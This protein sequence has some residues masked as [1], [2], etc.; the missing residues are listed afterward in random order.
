MDNS[1]KLLSH[2]Y[3]AVSGLAREFN[4][5]T[6]I[7]GRIGSM[8]NISNVQVISSNWIQGHELYNVIKLLKLSLPIILRGNFSSVFFHMT[9]LQCALLSPIIKIRGRRQ[10]LWYAHTHKSR[11]LLF[12]SLF[13]T[14][15]V[16]STLGSCPIKRKS[17]IPIGQAI[18]QTLFHSIPYNNLHLGKLV[19][20][21]RFD[22]SKNI[23][24]LISSAEILKKEFPEIELTIIG[25]P[26]NLESNKWAASLVENSFHK[27]KEG[28]LTFMD[29][30][31]RSDIPDEMKNYGVFFHAYVGSLDKTLIESTMMGIPV[32]TLNPEY[33]SIFGSWSKTKSVDLNSE[34][35][36]FRRRTQSEI[37]EEISRRR[38][39]ALEY[40]SFKNWVAKLS[41]IL[42]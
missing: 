14:N 5:I 24:I 30:V 27:V 35:R 11:Y 22:K 23:D 39:I 32:V 38:S 26:G 3:E 16:T 36:A 1:S 42:K 33:L 7:T 21:G 13:V 19:H 15:I 31:L 18:D 25:S 4:K 2:Q 37:I 41:N 20:I 40:H 17:V 28:W 12:S 8:D 6:V 9:D 10:F 34:Y 29:S